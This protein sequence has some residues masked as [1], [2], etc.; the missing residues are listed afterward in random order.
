M[1]MTQKNTVTWKIDTLSKILREAKA[2]RNRSVESVPFYTKSCSYKLN[3]TFYPN[4][5]RSGK[6]T[7]LSVYN[8]VMKREHDATLPWLFQKS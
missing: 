7:H 2:G 6:N 1:Q 3:I 4:G 8:N 5:S